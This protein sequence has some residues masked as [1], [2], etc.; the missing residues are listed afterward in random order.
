MRYQ[1]VEKV[2]RKPSLADMFLRDNVVVNVLDPECMVGPERF[3]A[4]KRGNL[5]YIDVPDE[6]DPISYRDRL[7]QFIDGFG[8]TPSEHVAVE[9]TS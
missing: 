2:G 7:F 3:E 8:Y 5:L 1:F 9:S 6:F 4:R